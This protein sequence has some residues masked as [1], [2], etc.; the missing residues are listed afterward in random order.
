MVIRTVLML[1]LFCMCTAEASAACSPSLQ[2]N[3]AK[4]AVMISDRGC[5]FQTAMI[6]A[7]P[8]TEGEAGFQGLEPLPPVPFE[9]ECTLEEGVGINCKPDGV[10]PLAGAKYKATFDTNPVCGGDRGI[11]YTC[12]H[13]C[14]NGAPPYLYWDPYEC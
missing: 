1:L 12:V 7:T 2:G 6:F 9:S 14:E 5:E 11:R 8:H 3:S 10:S 13:G 4:F